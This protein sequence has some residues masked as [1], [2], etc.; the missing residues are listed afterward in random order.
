MYKLSFIGLRLEHKEYDRK[1][2]GRK[3]QKIDINNINNVIKVYNS[4]AY[5]IKAPEN[6]NFNK[7]CIQDAIKYNRPYRGFRCDYVENGQN[8]NISKIKPS[9]P[10]KKIIDK[11]STIV[12][13]NSQKK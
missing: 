12:K 2:L 10:S 9:A 7:T 1:P 8:E 6:K 4:M 13:L 3:V 11:I 5:A